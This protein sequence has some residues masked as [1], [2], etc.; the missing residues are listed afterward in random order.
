MVAWTGSLN[1]TQFV[2]Q[3]ARQMR[4]TPEFKEQN[5]FGQ[6]GCILVLKLPSA[7]KLNLAEPTTVIIAV[8]QEVK[9]KLTDGIY[10][11]KEFGV[12]EVADLETIQCV[13]G[14]IHDRGRWALIDWSNSMA[15]YVD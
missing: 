8:I 12:D 9:A 11:Y 6:L 2:D 5:S 1:T 10:Y 4:R 15:N 14:R 7:P 3:H 13:V